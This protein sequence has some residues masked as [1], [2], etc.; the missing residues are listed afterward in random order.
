MQF[1]NT[2]SVEVEMRNPDGLYRDL[3]VYI[4]S[5]KCPIKGNGFFAP[6]GDLFA[7]DDKELLYD[8]GP[9]KVPWTDD[10]MKAELVFV[11]KKCSTGWVASQRMLMTQPRACTL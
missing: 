3:V 6:F 9:T 1:P 7:W 4:R 10:D 11:E 8:I 5:E 2:I